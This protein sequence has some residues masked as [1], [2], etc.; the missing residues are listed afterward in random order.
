MSFVV[1]SLKSRKCFNKMFYFKKRY[2]GDKVNFGL[3]KYVF[4]GSY[5][6]KS[7]VF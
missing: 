1:V 5:V 7:N 6:K 4:Y 3:M 2:Q